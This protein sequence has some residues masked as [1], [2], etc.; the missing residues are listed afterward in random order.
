ML[1]EL[2]GVSTANAVGAMVLIV[3]ASDV[4]CPEPHKLI[5]V[6]IVS[7]LNHIGDY[8]KSACQPTLSGQF[9]SLCLQYDSSR[10]CPGI[11]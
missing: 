10:R 3:E 9:W 11:S 6:E 8:I 7:E 4:L 5:R 1:A 2:S